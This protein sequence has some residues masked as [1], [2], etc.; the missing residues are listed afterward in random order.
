MT[1]ADFE[2][3]VEEH[4][5]RGSAE[6]IC[7]SV[8]AAP[9]PSRK[10]RSDAF[11]GSARI[12][13]EKTGWTRDAES[14]S[15]YRVYK[16]FEFR[17]DVRW[18]ATQPAAKV[19][20]QW[21]TVRDDGSR[22]IDPVWATLDA[23]VFWAD[24]L[25]GWVDIKTRA[26]IE[27]T[28][29]DHPGFYTVEPDGTVLCPS[30]HA[31]AD[32]RG[33][34]YTV[35]V[36]DDLDPVEVA[37]AGYARSFLG[38][39]V[40]GSVADGLRILV[41]KRGRVTLGDLH[42]AGFLVDHVIAAAY[43]GEVYIDFRK[44]PLHEQELVFV[45]LDPTVAAAMSEPVVV[46]VGGKRPSSVH[47]A[48]GEE[49]LRNGQTYVIEEAA[50][51]RVRLALADGSGDMVTLGRLE[52]DA[53]VASGAMIGLGPADTDARANLVA[54]ERLFSGATPEG[55][56]RAE[57]RLAA[58]EAYWAGERSAF[59]TLGGQ[60]PTVAAVRKWQTRYRRHEEM[61]CGLAGL[62][63]GQQVG[64]PG[65]HLEPSTQ[66]LIA[67]VAASFY[68]DPGRI[69]SVA[70]LHRAIKGRAAQLKKARSIVV[71]VPSYPAVITW[72]DHQPRY[73]SAFRRK[74]HR[75]SAAVRP[76]APF[77][78]DAESP[79][80]QFPGH[81]AHGD[82]TPSDIQVPERFTR[83]G[84]QRPGQF[85]LVD[86]L[87]GKKVGESWY[88]GEADE[89]VVL[90]A[91]ADQIRR[92]GFLSE[93]YV[94]DNA[95]VH[96]CTRLQQFLA[97]HG[98]DLVY[99]RKADGRAGRPVE[100]EFGAIN[101]DALHSMRG[102]TKIAREVRAMDPSLDP[103]DH[104]TWPFHELVAAVRKRDAAVEATRSIATL[105]M[106]T[107]EAWDR[108]HEHGVRAARLVRWSPRIERELGVRHPYQPKISNVNGIWVNRL[109]YWH[110]S[111]DHPALEGKKVR[112][113]TIRRDIGR[114][115]AF[116]P[117][118][119]HD[120]AGVR[121]EWV[122]CATRSPIG[123]ERVAID[124]LGYFTKVVLAYNE[125]HYARKKIENGTLG[126][127]LVERLD[128]EVDLVRERGQIRERDGRTGEALPDLPR[129]DILADAPEPAAAPNP[130]RLTVVPAAATTTLAAPI[131]RLGARRDRA[132]DVAAALAASRGATR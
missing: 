31:F 10:T 61:G 114:V 77:D 44:Q 107:N 19:L 86:G 8:W 123:R 17:R 40:P 46:S 98:S 65:S 52:V 48:R 80:G 108:R 127:L 93:V 24:R 76:W 82:A 84:A 35:I 49:V 54:I 41:A 9:G 66:A 94:L 26:S 129:G 47:L 3:Y 63:E 53:E 70:D 79:N 122:E 113:T 115:W 7:R 34:S 1:P 57:E 90:E 120:G 16:T 59:P 11:H 101:T 131:T 104:A 92:C 130:P 51:A 111:F 110:P 67:E 88:L 125:G 4:R 12:A 58:L 97:R 25:P 102:N 106:T 91:V 2:A 87:T 89:G 20:R 72:V 23:F 117:G 62:I 85:R 121:G 32:E 18:Y 126:D 96:K 39:E 118:H 50:A 105:R 64:R 69:P 15:E 124:E 13:S 56:E 68:F 21:V 37:N 119:T 112:V 100:R 75:G 5:L 116:V 81:V 45:Y 103:R 60:V 73:A 55:V 43:A 95:L 132:S 74:G 33:L 22:R 6:A 28:I 30:A 78:P 27:K 99:R 83:E 71:A 36:V 29:E 38:I 128:Q 42:R 109:Y 14:I